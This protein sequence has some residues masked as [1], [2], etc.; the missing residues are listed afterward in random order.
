MI[1]ALNCISA[2]SCQQFTSQTD[3][4]DLSL[5]SIHHSAVEI[6]GNQSYTCSHRDGKAFEAMVP[7]S[8]EMVSGECGV[9]EVNNWN[10]LRSRMPSQINHQRS[11][12]Q[13][14]HKGCKGLTLE[15]Y[16]KCSTVYLIYNFVSLAC[17]SLTSTYLYL[18]LPASISTTA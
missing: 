14:Q 8:I 13:P 18:A 17:F 7:V 15:V 16:R 1:E 5:W 10:D 4:A 12:W 2:W 6:S 11:C 9:K 3:P